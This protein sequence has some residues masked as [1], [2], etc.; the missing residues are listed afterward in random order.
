[1]MKKK[2]EMDKQEKKLEKI[3]EQLLLR[4]K[5]TVKLM[6]HLKIKD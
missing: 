5:D 3:R 6:E 1:M 4:E 2:E